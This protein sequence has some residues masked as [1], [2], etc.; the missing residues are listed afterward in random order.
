VPSTVTAAISGSFCALTLA[1]LDRPVITFGLMANEIPQGERTGRELPTK[2]LGKRKW[3]GGLVAA[4]GLLELT[5]RLRQKKPFIP[6]GVHRF[7][8]FEESDA[9][10]LKMLARPPRRGHRS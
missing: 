8:S 4:A 3:R 10:S 6:K 2:V 9:W 7:A 5:V 1:G